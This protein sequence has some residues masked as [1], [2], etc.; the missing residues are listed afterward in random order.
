MKARHCT[1]QTLLCVLCW[2]FYDVVGLELNNGSPNYEL[3]SHAQQSCQLIASYLFGWQVCL[4]GKHHE[5]WGK[6]RKRESKQDMYC[7]RDH[8]M[9]PCETK[10]L[11]F[12]NVLVHVCLSSSCI[13]PEWN[14]HRSFS[15]NYFLWYV[16][17]ILYFDSKVCASLNSILLISQN[18]HKLLNYL[19][20]LQ[21]FFF[22]IDSA[23]L[24]ASL[25]IEN[26]MC[27]RTDPFIYDG[28]VH[29]ESCIWKFQDLHET[30]NLWSNDTC[31]LLNLD[32][33]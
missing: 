27:M 23:S 9:R 11:T 29:M 25:I 1:L 30:M 22:R 8:N 26:W 24:N 20:L 6:E 33:I 12:Q 28:N 10:H 4:D 21:N 18:L 16:L 31:I 3:V 2:T 7:Q 15:F 5:V 17:S 13:I 14:V 19:Y 32:Y